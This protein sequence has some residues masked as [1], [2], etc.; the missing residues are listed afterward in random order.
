[1]VEAGASAGGA[2]EGGVFA[3][4]NMTGGDVA[5]ELVACWICAGGVEV[6][7]S[8]STISGAGDAAGAPLGSP[9][10]GAS[11]ASAADYNVVVKG[12]A[13]RATDA[14]ILRVRLLCAAGEERGKA[15]P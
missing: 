13:H 14:H 11:A 10:A 1:M 4:S 7:V 8:V 3:L 12:A 2:G 5:G 6:A 9:I 15:L